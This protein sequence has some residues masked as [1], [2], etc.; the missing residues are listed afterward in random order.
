MSLSKF[1]ELV[2]DRGAW[3]ATILGVAKSHTQLSDW[4]ELSSYIYPLPPELPSPLPLHPTPLSWQSEK[5][6]WIRSDVSDS[7]RPHGLQATSSSFHGI[8]QARVLEWVAMSFSR[9]SSQPRDRTWVS[10]ITGRLFTFW[11]TKGAPIW[12]PETTN[13]HWLP[14]FPVVM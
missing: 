7:L 5:W 10:R 3:R 2:M 14:T 13:S 6:K 1:Q 11:A 4:T 9:G 12:V 8:F